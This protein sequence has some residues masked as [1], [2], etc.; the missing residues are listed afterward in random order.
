MYGIWE[1]NKCASMFQFE[2]DAV[3]K[4]KKADCEQRLCETPNCGLFCNCY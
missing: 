4:E 3:Q 2:A 1:G